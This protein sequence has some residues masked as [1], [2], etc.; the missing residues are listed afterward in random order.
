MGVISLCI[1][2][3]S[4]VFLIVFELDKKLGILMYFSSVIINSGSDV[5]L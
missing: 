4:L 5:M 3:I 2:I 1:Q